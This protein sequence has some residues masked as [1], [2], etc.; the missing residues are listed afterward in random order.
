MALTA[1]TLA[2]RAVD[3]AQLHAEL[4][5]RARDIFNAGRQLPIVIYDLGFTLFDSRPRVMK[6]LAD[7]ILS[8]DAAE[9]A[10]DVRAAVASIRPRM[11]QPE[12]ASTLAAAGV[13]D[14]AA[15]AWLVEQH[16]SKAA[17]D[18]Y[19]MFDL[20]TPGAVEFV[21]DLSKAG[22]MTVYLAGDR[23][24]ARARFGTERSISMYELPAPRGQV[25]ALFIRDRDDQP[26]LEFKRELLGPIGE[27][28][29]VIAAFD[30]EPA[31][32][33][34]YADTFPDARTVL[35]DTFRAGDDELRPGI[36]VLRDFR[37]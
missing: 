19:V 35:L 11:M 17:T 12:L 18:Q 23:H 9:L 29:A 10:D 15:I 13:T 25:G 20:P 14:E 5:E 4:A 3:P 32:A 30:N 6:L 1:E 33:N 37:R 22:A 7:L 36:S 8:P 21:K 26:E 27:L 2:A 28:G 34:L 31:A 16:E 24:I